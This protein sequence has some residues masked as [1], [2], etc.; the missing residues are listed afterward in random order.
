MVAARVHYEVYGRRAAGAPWTL[1]LAT[2]DRRT[3]TQTAQ[4][5]MTGGFAAARVT[6]ET[7]DEE[8]RE[9]ST[10]AILHLGAA[11]TKKGAVAATAEP[12]C[13][14]PQDLYTLHA[15]GRIARLLDGW[16]ERKRVTAYE[17]LHRPDLVEQLEASGSDLQHALQKIAIPEASARGATVHEILRSFH[18]LVDRSIERL[19][20]DHHRGALADLSRESFAHAAERLHREA[21]GAYLLGAGVAG[22]LADAKTWSEKINMLLDLADEAPQGPARKFALGV[23]EQPLAET[24]SARGAVHDLFG[25]SLDLGSELAGLT[26]LAAGEAVDRLIRAEPQVAKVMPPLE[27]TA[28]RLRRWIGGEGFAEVRTALGKRILR[29]ISGLRRLRPTDAADEIEILRALAMSLTAA[30]GKLLPL[31]QVQAAFTTRSKALVAGDFVNAYLAESRTAY[32]EVLAMISLTENVIGQTNKG[33]AS[34]WLG[35]LVGALKFEGEVCGGEEPPSARLA[36][37]AG[38]QRAVGRCG[39]APED[40]ERI[41]SRLGELGGQVEASA[42]LTTTLA[43][44]QAPL[45]Q[46]LT[47]LLRLAA[48]DT[49]PFGPAADRARQE[50]IKLFRDPEMR[51]KLAAAPTELQAMRS[52]IQ[53]AGLAA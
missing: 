49:A 13:I 17:L 7:F 11:E 35:S 9:F 31:D 47:L 25:K 41:Q 50:A 6:K 5:V 12:L 2:E 43:R 18:T 16:L 27:S 32:D 14:K 28:E 4:D 3:A 48:G 15:R 24:L 42:K 45:M 10:V 44:A 40:S 21:E 53:Q 1:E 20:K 51:A 30:A 52:L 22:R 33:H 38:L 26:R 37:L 34:R 39:L 19:M 29:E 8:T 23:L 46:K 36:K